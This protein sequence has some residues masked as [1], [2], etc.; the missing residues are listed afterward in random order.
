MRTP[1][2]GVFRWLMLNSSE[3]VIQIAGSRCRERARRARPGRATEGVRNRS[4]PTSGDALA[5]NIG[6]GMM[7]VFVRAE[8]R[9]AGLRN[10]PP[11]MPP[12]SPINSKPV[13]NTP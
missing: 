10:A 3:R 5:R 6:V 7:Y 12:I 2:E 13:K 8:C 11:K 1:G 9:I 4:V